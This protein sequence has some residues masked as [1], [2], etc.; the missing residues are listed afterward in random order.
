MLGFGMKTSVKDQTPNKALQTEPLK[1]GCFKGGSFE[2]V[3]R[4]PL[5]FRV[6]VTGFLPGL[7]DSKHGLRV[8]GSR[9]QRLYQSSIRAVGSMRAFQTSRAR[10]WQ[11]PQEISSKKGS[12]YSEVSVRAYRLPRNV[13]EWQSSM[14]CGNWFKY[15]PQ[16]PSFRRLQGTW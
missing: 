7:E 5:R 6:L 15:A 4:V 8:L 9:A 10:V 1:T 16:H 13:G 2:V 11:D 12:F 3:L 14:L